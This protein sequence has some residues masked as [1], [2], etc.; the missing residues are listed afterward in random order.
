ML[1]TRDQEIDVELLSAPD[2]RLKAL[3]LQLV[4]LEADDDNQQT[5]ALYGEPA[6]I[7]S[8]SDYAR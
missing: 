6:V 7:G 8:E 2:E 4:L 1:R 5:L 3:R